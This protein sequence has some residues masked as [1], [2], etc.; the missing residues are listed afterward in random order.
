MSQ[1]PCL[2]EDT[3]AVLLMDCNLLGNWRLPRDQLEDTGKE[4]RKELEPPWK[5]CSGGEMASNRLGCN[6][7][8]AD[9]PGMVGCRQCM[10]FW[11]V[12]NFKPSPLAWERNWL[13]K[14]GNLWARGTTAG[15][16]GGGTEPQPGNPFSLARF[17]LDKN[18]ICFISLNPHK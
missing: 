2:A 14:R 3:L 1:E 13:Q 9:A 16:V 17:L 6:K 7:V 8:S 5:E 15:V 12:L 18:L 10:K 4:P 11:K